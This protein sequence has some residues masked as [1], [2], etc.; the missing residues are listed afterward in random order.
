MHVLVELTALVV[1]IALLLVVCPEGQTVRATL[2]PSPADG[3][4]CAVPKRRG[5]A[6]VWTVGLMTALAPTREATMARRE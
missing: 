3:A 4:A 6:F 1:S 5:R 2:L